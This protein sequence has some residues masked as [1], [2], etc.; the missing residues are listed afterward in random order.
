LHRLLVKKGLSRFGGIWLP[1]SLVNEEQVAFY[2][3]Q[4]T[5]PGGG[6][7]AWDI[8]VAS[9]DSW[10]SEGTRRTTAYFASIEQV[11]SLKAIYRAGAYR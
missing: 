9:V 6:P 8:A 10:Y 5:F 2:L 4:E 11:N 1:N 3:V 7:Y